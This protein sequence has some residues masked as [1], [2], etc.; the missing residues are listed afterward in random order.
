M[1][2]YGSDD[3]GYMATALD[4]IGGQSLPPDELVLVQDG[5][6]PEE[7]LAVVKSWCATTSIPNTLIVLRENSGLANALNEGLGRCSSEWVARMD[8]DDVMA[9]DRLLKQAAFLQRNPGIDVVGGQGVRVDSAGSECGFI[10]VPV[11]ERVI[12]KNM[13]ANPFLHPSVC[14]R[15]SAIVGLGG[16]STDTRRAED[17]EL[18]LRAQKA[19]LK[20]ANLRDVLVYYR[21]DEEHYSKN[22]RLVDRSRARVAFW[23]CWNNGLPLLGYFGAFWLFFRSFLPAGIRRKSHT[24]MAWL[25]PRRSAS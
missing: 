23:G 1:A 22:D 14:Y 18:W 8:A 13:W 2:F 9:K 7:L 12:Y 6:V 15:K 25:D 10:R 3:P 16:Y 11:D 21:V 17:M 24:V 5:P 20:F 4:S 19:G